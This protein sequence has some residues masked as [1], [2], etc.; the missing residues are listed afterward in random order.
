MLH[1]KTDEE[2]M[3][4]VANGHRLAFEHLVRRHTSYATAMARRFSGTMGSEA[5]DIVQDA[6]IK[7]W[8]NASSWSGGRAKFT[9]WLY[10]IIMNTGI[11]R[12]RAQK[13]PTEIEWEM[14]PDT[15]A[16]AEAKLVDRQ[17]DD[18]VA[19]AIRKLPE[20][21]RMALAL[22]YQQDMTNREAADVMNIHI[23]AFEAQLG[24]ARRALKQELKHFRKEKIS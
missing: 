5:D 3:E 15:A 22:C 13:T 24:R 4:L 23:K 12:V 8:V 1:E 9:T 18:V 10:R 2:L 14:L 6:F 11:D 17:E 20:K 19:Q 7:V 16:N 21:Q